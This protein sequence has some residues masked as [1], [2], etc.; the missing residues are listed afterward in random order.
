M[1][2]VRTCHLAHF[3]LCRKYFFALGITLVDNSCLI[4]VCN[5]LTGSGGDF[6]SSFGDKGEREGR[7]NPPVGAATVKTRLGGGGSTEGP[8]TLTTPRARANRFA[9][10]GPP[11][12]PGYK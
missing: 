3:S 4:A 10:N 7:R 6:Q 8:A 5:T 1:F 9:D 12:D 2:S 11:P